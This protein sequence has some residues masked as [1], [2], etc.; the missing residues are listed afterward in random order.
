MKRPSW[1]DLIGWMSFGIGKLLKPR[2]EFGKK[3]LDKGVLISIGWIFLVAVWFCP[4]ASIIVGIAGMFFIT[5]SEYVR[6]DSFCVKCTRLKV[7]RQMAE[8]ISLE[9]GYGICTD[10]YAGR[11]KTM[12]ALENLGTAITR[13]GGDMEI[14]QGKES[15][16]AA[17]PDNP[18]EEHYWTDDE[19]SR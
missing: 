19:T 12:A 3:R 2:D 5:W 6:Y 15:P 7:R 1:Y 18:P 8:M 17:S 10:C 14:A 16:V 13:Y 11:E 4:R 9:T